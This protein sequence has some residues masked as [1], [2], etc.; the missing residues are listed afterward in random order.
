M[1][2]TTKKE[3]KTCLL[4]R[5]KMI[6]MNDVEGIAI[7][8]PATVFNQSISV[9]T[10]LLLG[11]EIMT[12]LGPYTL[13]MSSSSRLSPLSDLIVTTSLFSLS[14]FPLTKRK[15]PRLFNKQKNYP[16]CL[17]DILRTTQFC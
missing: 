15:I 4:E 7:Q 13:L 5:P 3:Q 9:D 10:Q 11:R 12:V 6:L 14:A 17:T 2:T 8:N 1:M 16:N